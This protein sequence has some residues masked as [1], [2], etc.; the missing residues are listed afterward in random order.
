MH[1]VTGAATDDEGG[2]HVLRDGRSGAAAGKGRGTGVDHANEV[3]AGRDSGEGVGG[4]R[5]LLIPI[6]KEHGGRGGEF[7]TGG[8]AHDADFVGV[9]APFLCISADHADG[10]LGVIN[11]VRLGVVAILAEAVA[12]DDGVDAVVVKERDEVRAFAAHVEGV[13]AS[14]GHQDN[15][16]AGVDGLFHHVHFER[17]V[18]DVDN[19][20]DAAGDRAAHVVDLGLPHF[21]GLEVGRIGR[22]ERDDDAAGDDGLRCVRSVGPGAWFGD[23]LGRRKRRERFLRV[24]D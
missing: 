11:G 17:R 15:R 7:R 20:A 2:R 6:F 14:A 19:A 1:T 23:R 13:V 4:V 9:D 12:E 10:L 22:V 16:R 21:I 18:V 5:V 8:E 3:R 24:G